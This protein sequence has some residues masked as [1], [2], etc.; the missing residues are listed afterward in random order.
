[1]LGRITGLCGVER[2]DVPGAIAEQRA[3]RPS[4]RGLWQGSGR[5]TVG[6]LDVLLLDVCYVRRNAMGC[7]IAILARTIPALLPG[8]VA[9]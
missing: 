3:A 6:T 5:S 2:R 8:E 9:Q 7:H 1:M 4:V